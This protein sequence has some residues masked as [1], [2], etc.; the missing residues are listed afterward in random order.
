MSNIYYI[1]Q[2]KSE[3]ETLNLEIRKSKCKGLFLPKKHFFKKNKEDQSYEI[4][5]PYFKTIQSLNKDI[6]LYEKYYSR[7]PFLIDPTKSKDDLKEKIFEKKEEFEKLFKDS[8]IETYFLS[9]ITDYLEII[10]FTEILKNNRKISGIEK[11]L[12]QKRENFRIENF[13]I[14]YLPEI[15]TSFFDKSEYYHTICESNS[16]AIH[17]LKLYIKKYLKSYD[18]DNQIFTITLTIEDYLNGKCNLNAIIKDAENFKK[19]GLWII[20]FN[21]I[22]ASR[23]Q[24]EIYNKIVSFFYEKTSS[25]FVYYSGIYS[26][27]LLD[28]IDPNINK[29]VRISG[30]PGLNIN[31]P[32]MAPRTKRFLY[33][34]N[35][36]FYNPNNFAQELLKKESRLESHCNCE[37]CINHKINKLERIF[38]FY[39][40]N[41][42]DNPDYYEYHGRADKTLEQKL[43]T[44]QNSFLIRHNF[45][46]LD[47]LLHLPLKKLYNFFFINNK[48]LQNWKEFIKP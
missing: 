8:N 46:N 5:E 20:D 47:H 30:Y 26:S 17:N 33:Q 12:F 14:P 9:E 6:I 35:G 36:N 13:I 39:I 21:D 1:I 2:F 4:N 29:I 28:R 43:K 7:R 16:K 19:I 24:I 3:I 44:K 15:P 37:I 48:G 10:S 31:I 11:K 42:K 27:K 40:R 18:L 25:L 22:V 32:S 38:D 41:P 34:G 23:K 45:Y